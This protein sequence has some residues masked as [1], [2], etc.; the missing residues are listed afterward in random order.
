MNIGEL[1]KV[2]EKLREYKVDA[3]DCS[4]FISKLNKRQVKNILNFNFDSSFMDKNEKYTY[5]INYEDVLGNL[6]LL[7]YDKFNEAV[8]ILFL[9]LNKIMVQNTDLFG[10]EV[11]NGI[12][13]ILECE[14]AINNDTLLDD[15]SHI[16]NKMVVYEELQ[17]SIKG[18]FT[19]PREL[20]VMK[21]CILSM[22]SLASN[23]V[24]LNGKTH[25][26]V[27]NLIYNSNDN[28]VTDAL[29]KV[30]TSSLSVDDPNTKKVLTIIAKTRGSYAKIMADFVTNKMARKSEFFLNWLNSMKASKSIDEIKTLY[31]VLSD[32]NVQ[33]S[34]YHYYIVSLIQDVN[35][36]YLDLLEKICLDKNLLHSTDFVQFLKTVTNSESRN[37]AEKNT[38]IILN[39][40]SDYDELDVILYNA[41]LYADRN[42]NEEDLEIPA[43]VLRLS[44]PKNSAINDP[45][46][47]NE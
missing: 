35:P 31:N 42:G 33:N 4:L 7:N 30:E 44:K 37:E 15:V 17:K 43:E 38:N 10:D 20:N 8:D 5:L 29:K 25:K 14:S 22:I 47:S 24:S 3:S 41:L 9:K 23:E 1:R 45:K 36:D 12:R 34:S 2:I 32:E 21:N 28:L 11:A 19:T 40:M 26:L 18:L 13:K 16:M 46:N 27:M 6:K 39:N